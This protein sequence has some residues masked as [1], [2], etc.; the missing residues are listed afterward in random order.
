MVIFFLRHPVNSM[1]CPCP[2]VVW[3]S[4]R[5]SCLQW[6]L[7]NRPSTSGLGATSSTRSSL[8]LLIV[9]IN[10]IVYFSFSKNF[11]YIL[12]ISFFSEFTRIYKL[13]IVLVFL[14]IS[15]LESWGTT[16]LL[17]WQPPLI[18]VDLLQNHTS[19][20]HTMRAYAQEVWDK[21]NKD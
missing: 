10:F 4:F 20:S 18:F 11:S 21:S 17:N 13:E 1:H 9:F 7:N 14:G 5:S 19:T 6:T 2:R 16:F 8:Y 12:W 3:A 15:H